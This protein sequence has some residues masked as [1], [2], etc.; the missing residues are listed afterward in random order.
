MEAIKDILQI[1]FTEQLTVPTWEVFSVLVVISI[2]MLLRA[3][4]T[5]ILTTYVFTLHLAVRFANVHFDTGGQMAFSLGIIILFLA[6]VS[7][8]W[9][10]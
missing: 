8:I 7:I 2:A 9:K 6:L 3:S 5:G 10:R 1:M 4:K